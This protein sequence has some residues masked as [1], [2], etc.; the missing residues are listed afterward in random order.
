MNRH[1][2]T[3]VKATIWNLQPEIEINQY[4]S[5]IRVVL[6]YSRQPYQQWFID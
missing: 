2:F 6:K 1:I 5:S 3:I 4:Y